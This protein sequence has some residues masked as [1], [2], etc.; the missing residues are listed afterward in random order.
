MADNTS[1]NRF[2]SNLKR[3]NTMKWEDYWPQQI[4]EPKM[5][6]EEKKKY[7]NETCQLPII[8]YLREK[9]C[10]IRFLFV[11]PLSFAGIMAITNTVM[12][13]Y[14]VNQT[15]C[16]ESAKFQKYHIL[17]GIGSVLV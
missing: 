9:N 12:M 17:T 3:R 7:D 15:M 14:E 8:K 13:D 4:P 10:F 5:T 6:K 11:Y 16:F 1:F 2:M